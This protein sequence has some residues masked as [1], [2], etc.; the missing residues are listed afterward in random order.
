MDAISLTVT[1]LS[2][3]VVLGIISYTSNKKVKALEEYI[4]GMSMTNLFE[5]TVRD[6][7]MT[8]KQKKVFSELK[9]EYLEYAEESL[10]SEGFEASFFADS[11]R[12]TVL[13][14]AR[15]LFL[16]DYGK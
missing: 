4:K 3:T 7:V 9:E 8:S 5:W 11:S 14:K 6:E 16:D 1:F 12:A 10:R 2:L 15:N 13:T